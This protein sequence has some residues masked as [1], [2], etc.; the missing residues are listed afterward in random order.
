[1]QTDKPVAGNAEDDQQTALTADKSRN[2]KA[3]WKDK[4]MPDSRKGNDEVSPDDDEKP[5]RP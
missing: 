2:D 4:D 3:R 1:M 5:P